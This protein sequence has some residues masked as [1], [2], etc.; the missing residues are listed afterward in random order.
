MTT[1]LDAFLLV[2]GTY[3]RKPG[4]VAVGIEFKYTEPEFGRCGG[5]VSE[6]NS[7]AGRQACIGLFETDE[8]DRRQTCYLRNEK[9]RLYLAD[10]DLEK[11]FQPDHNPL[12]SA[13]PCLL[14]GPANQIFRSQF[15][16]WKLKEA[17]D[18]CQD[19]M[20][21]VL[22]HDGNKV[23]FEP[24]RTIPHLPQF[25]AS[26]YDRYRATLMPAFQKRLG[27]ITTNQA[28]SAYERHCGQVNWV[29]ELKDRY[30]F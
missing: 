22:H 14:L 2:T 4:R 21:F 11:F 28:I 20:F 12:T 9:Q 16:T 29:Q 13:G 17:I 3:N 23:L 26:A 6:G 5:F 19:W 24:E 25:E 7:L 18:C 27:I 15:T 1:R 30:F 8:S 10:R